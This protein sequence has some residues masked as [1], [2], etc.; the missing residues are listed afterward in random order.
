MDY[1]AF[2]AGAY[3]IAAGTL[4]ALI[5]WAVVERRAARRAMSRAERAVDGS[6]PGRG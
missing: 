4:V 3:A 6:R 5:V 2:V 1:L